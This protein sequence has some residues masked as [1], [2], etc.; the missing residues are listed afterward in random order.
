MENK[1]HNILDK[2]NQLVIKKKLYFKYDS[3]KLAP[4]ITNIVNTCFHNSAIQLLY[5]MSDLVAYLIRNDIRMEYSLDNNMNAV[6]ELLTLMVK[7]SDNLANNVIN[8]NELDMVQNY[9]CKFIPNYKKNDQGDALELLKYILN[10]LCCTNYNTQ[11]KH[12][13]LDPR[14]SF[15]YKHTNYMCLT[16]DCDTKNYKLW[17]QVENYYNSALLLSMNPTNLN[18]SIEKRLE[19]FTKFKKSSPTPS[20]IDL[21]FG[22]YIIFDI[23]QYQMGTNINF[24]KIKH[25]I[26]LENFIIVNSKKYELIGIT[27]YQGSGSVGHYYAYIKYNNKWYEYNDS[28]RSAPK[29]DYDKNYLVNDDPNGS[30]P[31]GL[32]YIKI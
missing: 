18:Y 13:D 32:L 26:P 3:Y 7:K 23:E 20:K 19:N 11:K 1:I 4:G 2:I 6:I 21:D 14:V 10:A 29:D 12:N 28:Y 25:K 24:K 30:Q 17:D 8:D 9:I 22:N 27:Y 31:S 5:R 15:A 16:N